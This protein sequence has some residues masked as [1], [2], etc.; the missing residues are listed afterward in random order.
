MLIDKLH[1]LN[2]TKRLGDFPIAAPKISGFVR[3]IFNFYFEALSA[4]PK[5]PDRPA[6][7]SVPVILRTSPSAPP[8][9]KTCRAPI[10]HPPPPA[11]PIIVGP[12]RR[13]D[14]ERAGEKRKKKA[15]TRC[16]AYQYIP[17][18]GPVSCH[19]T[20]TTHDAADFFFLPSDAC[21][22]TTAIPSWITWFSRPSRTMDGP[23]YLLAEASNFCGETE[24]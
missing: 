7:T 4:R 9:H 11:R 16:G 21:T 1:I 23:S 19:E 2:A 14:L 18:E 20:S 13:M 24:Q 3:L 5:C 15:S 17:M 12:R 8:L 10:N 6:Q 22:V